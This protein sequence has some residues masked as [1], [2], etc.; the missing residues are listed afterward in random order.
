MSLFDN[1]SGYCDVTFIRLVEGVGI[2]CN[3][4]VFRVEVRE[5]GRK[6]AWDALDR[7]GD[8]PRLP[9]RSRT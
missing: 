7:F 8:L 6:E 1:V 2:R 9:S 5:T 3:G 4:V